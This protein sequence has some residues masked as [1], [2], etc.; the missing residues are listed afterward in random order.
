MGEVVAEEEE[1]RPGSLCLQIEIKRQVEEE[2]V[3]VEGTIRDVVEEM[4]EEKV[5]R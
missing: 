1:E 2:E 4:K 3:E 5:Q